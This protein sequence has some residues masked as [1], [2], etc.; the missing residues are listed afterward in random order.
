MKEHG[1]YLIKDEYVNLINSLGGKYSDSKERPIYCCL[2]DN[3][4]E[5]LYWLIPTSDLSHRTKAQIEKYQQYEQCK[6]IRSAYYYIGKTTKPALYKIS[7]ALP[8]SDKYI[9]REYSDSNQHLVLADKKAIAII[10]Q[11]LRRILSYENTHKNKLEQHISDVKEHISNELLKDKEL[12]SDKEIVVSS[13]APD[14]ETLRLKVAASKLHKENIDLQIEN[15]ELSME[16]E[17]LKEQLAQVREQSKA[18]SLSNSV[19][20]AKPTKPKR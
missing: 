17:S 20:S 4:I 1:F 9:L 14:E 12:N 11:K 8:I 15:A 19:P 3:K 13:S 16:N 10:E 5:G 6:D 18:E 2:K 7:N